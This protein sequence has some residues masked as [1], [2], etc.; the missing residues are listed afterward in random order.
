MSKSEEE[1]GII[2]LF[3][4]SVASDEPELAI[5]EGVPECSVVPNLQLVPDSNVAIQEGE[6]CVR[7]VLEEIEASDS[8][9]EEASEGESF[10]DIMGGWTM[11]L[12]VSQKDSR[13]PTCCV[14]Q[15]S[16]QKLYWK[17]WSVFLICN[18]VSRH[19]SYSFSF[20]LGSKIMAIYILHELVNGAR[21]FMKMAS[22]GFVF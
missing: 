3:G 6:E 5:D 16:W 1:V 17:V 21:L 15:I 12:E 20:S 4:G 19:S 11:R 22:W 2:S 18:C 8:W 14:V 13:L 9:T 10:V 7:R